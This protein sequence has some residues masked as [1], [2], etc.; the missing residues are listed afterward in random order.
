[1][2]KDWPAWT[3]VYHTQGEYLGLCYE[4]YSSGS[5]ADIRYQTLRL[6]DVAATKRPFHSSDRPHM[7]PCDIWDIE[8]PDDKEVNDVGG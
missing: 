1:M 7:S 5:A 3:I 8:G 6:A 4:F 2:S